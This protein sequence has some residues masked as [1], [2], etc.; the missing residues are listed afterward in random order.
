MFYDGELT[1]VDDCIASVD[2]PNVCY[3]QGPQLNRVCGTP[4][5]SVPENLSVCQ[6]VSV[7]PD[8]IDSSE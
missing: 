7:V 6:N 1:N 3:T 2:I 8:T 5:D 4:T